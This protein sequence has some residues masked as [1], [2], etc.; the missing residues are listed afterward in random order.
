MSRQIL[1]SCVVSA[2]KVK[3]S[4]TVLPTLQTDANEESN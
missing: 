3:R 4:N 2:L 1:S